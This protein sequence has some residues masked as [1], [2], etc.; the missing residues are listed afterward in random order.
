[1]WTQVT[2]F[3]SSWAEGP[4]LEPLVARA[5]HLKATVEDAI[6]GVGPHQGSARESVP[7][8]N[9]M[10]SGLTLVDEL[11]SAADLYSTPRS[12]SAFN[13][14]IDT[15]T[16]ATATF[17][18]CLYLA[19]R[20]HVIELLLSL[21]ITLGEPT[22]AGDELALLTRQGAA[23]IEAICDH[24][25]AVFGFDGREVLDLEGGPGNPHRIWCMIWPMT[26]VLSSCLAEET[27][28]GWVLDK[29]YRVGKATGFGVAML[30]A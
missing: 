30:T 17:A 1:L 13:S 22:V 3:K 26:S 11:K 19:V 16:R 8:T 27:T 4:C 6:Q 7:A 9:L 10:E 25:C 24:I 20:Q 29:F 18:R 23:N 21:V 12:A 2:N 5:V 28:K 15:S 14:L